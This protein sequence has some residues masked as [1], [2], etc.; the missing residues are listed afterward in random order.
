MQE[1][2]N[3]SKAVKD[4]VETYIDSFIAWDLILFFND[5]PY[6]VGSAS[7]VAMSIGRRGVDIEPHLEDLVKRNVLE[8]E[9]KAD[10]NTETLYSYNPP[11]GFEKTVVEF[12]R[13]LRDRAA[14]HI[15]VSK[16]LEKE[17]RK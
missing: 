3:I 16:V 6:T 4:F 9:S 13:A 8:L 7:N 14:R 11:S 2:E 17:A 10:D 1:F 5:N 12:R 15:I